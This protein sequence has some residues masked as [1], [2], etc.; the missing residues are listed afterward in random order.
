LTA[1]HRAARPLIPQPIRSGSCLPFYAT[2]ARQER[3][4]ARAGKTGFDLS[5]ELV[6]RA[7]SELAL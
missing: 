3:E 1:A 5:D 4:D 6:A 2:V 7:S